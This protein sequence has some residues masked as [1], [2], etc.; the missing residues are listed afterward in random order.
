MKRLHK[1]SRTR[2][3]LQATRWDLALVIEIPDLIANSAF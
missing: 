2:L 1:Q 3:F